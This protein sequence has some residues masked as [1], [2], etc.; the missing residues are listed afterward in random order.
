MYKKFKKNNKKLQEYAHSIIPGLSGL[1]GKDQRCTCRR[2]MATYYSKAKGIN[3]WDL[4]G[5]KYL[6]FTMIGVGS[7]C[8]WIFRSRY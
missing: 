1:L 8:A 4:K 6:D 3:I 7:M 2:K 5:K